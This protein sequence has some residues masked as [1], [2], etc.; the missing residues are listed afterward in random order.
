MEVFVQNITNHTDHISVTFKVYW[1]KDQ[2]TSPKLFYAYIL[3]TNMHAGITTKD[4]LDT[5]WDQVKNTAS[6]YFYWENELGTEFTELAGTKY[7]PTGNC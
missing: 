6:T 1:N 2:K 3:H 7:I 5:A 4:I